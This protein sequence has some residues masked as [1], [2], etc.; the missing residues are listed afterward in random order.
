MSTFPIGAGGDAK[1]AS[2]DKTASCAL[3][4]GAGMLGTGGS[5]GSPGCADRRS[6]E[7]TCRTTFM[8]GLTLKLAG[9]LSGADATTRNDR[10]P[11]SSSMSAQSATGRSFTLSVTTHTGVKMGEVEICFAKLNFFNFF[12]TCLR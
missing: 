12:L 10:L 3:I 8:L 5:G 7:S 6:G 4:I 2:G 11:P 9:A 1:A